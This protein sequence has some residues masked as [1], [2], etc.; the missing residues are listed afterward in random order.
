MKYYLPYFLRARA[1]PEAEADSEPKKKKNHSGN[2][3]FFNFLARIRILKKLIQ[4][5]N[6]ACPCI[7]EILPFWVWGRSRF[8]KFA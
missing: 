7:I 2:A 8:F 5:H 3:V 6:T 4:I 1:E